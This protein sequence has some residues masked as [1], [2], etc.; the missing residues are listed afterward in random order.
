ML[1]G[2]IML[3][4]EFKRTFSNVFLEEPTEITLVM[5][6]AYFSNPPYRTEWLMDEKPLGF[7]HSQVEQIFGRDTAVDLAE[8]FRVRI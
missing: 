1:Y 5:I 3:L 8:D 4:S 6:A 2:N 7:V